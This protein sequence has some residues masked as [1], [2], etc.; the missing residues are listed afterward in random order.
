MHTTLRK[1]LC[2]VMCSLACLVV[3]VAAFVAS[4]GIQCCTLFWAVFSCESLLHVGLHCVLRAAGQTGTGRTL[5]AESNDKDQARLQGHTVSSDSLGQS[6]RAEPKPRAG[7][8][9]RK[10]WAR[11]WLQMSKG[12]HTS[13]L[14]LLTRYAREEA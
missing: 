14:Q 8:V 3:T 5:E 1:K 11:V 9:S 7:E 2:K 12:Y 10:T 4:S 13:F 6:H